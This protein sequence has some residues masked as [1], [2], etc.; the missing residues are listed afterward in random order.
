MV[1]KLIN[2][3]LERYKLKIELKRSENDN[4]SFREKLYKYYNKVQ[5]QKVELISNIIK[6]DNLVH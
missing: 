6:R 1:T 3:K 4:K 2:L 5:G